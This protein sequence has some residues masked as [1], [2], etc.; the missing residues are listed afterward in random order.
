MEARKLLMPLGR[1]GSHGMM[2]PKPPFMHFPLYFQ[3]GYLIILTV[4]TP[5]CGITPDFFSNPTDAH[6][7]VD[8]NGRFA[9]A[10]KYVFRR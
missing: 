9:L 2:Y 8:C 5:N 4:K 7:D 10:N 1:H 3:G 6:V